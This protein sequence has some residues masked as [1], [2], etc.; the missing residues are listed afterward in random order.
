VIQECGYALKAVSAKKRMILFVEKDVEIPTLQS[1]LEYIPFE[2][3]NYLSAIQKAS[4]MINAILSD[5]SGISV[6][7]TVSAHPPTVDA[8]PKDGDNSF[9]GETATAKPDSIKQCFSE[10]RDAIDAK[11]WERAATAFGTGLTSIRKVRPDAE[12]FWCAIY[13]EWRYEA[14]QPRHL[15]TSENLPRT[16]R[17][18][19]FPCAQLDTVLRAFTNTKGRRSSF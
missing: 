12:V 3:G 8:E 16:T 5:A 13:H 1:D 11:D 6:E 9:P 15:R 17:T 10:I 19:S 2:E 18:I 14:G 4:E 7:I